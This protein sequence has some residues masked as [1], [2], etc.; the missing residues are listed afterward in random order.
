MLAFH[1][2]ASSLA[3]LGIRALNQFC[4]SLLRKR[5]VIDMIYL[6]EFTEGWG[7]VWCCPS[8]PDTQALLNSEAF[9]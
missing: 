4:S 3:G 6:L 9:R 1:A 2:P 8:Y 7:E 5:A